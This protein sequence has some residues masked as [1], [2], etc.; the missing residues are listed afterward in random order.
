MKLMNKRYYSFGNP[1]KV[2]F[3]EHYCY[4]CGT[5]LFQTTHRK[6]VYPEAEEAKF[7]EFTDWDG[8]MFGPC[9]F[10]HKVFYCSECREEIEFITQ[11]NMEDIDCLL[12]KVE[13]MYNNIAQNTSSKRFSVNKY[14]ETEDGLIENKITKIENVRYLCISV[15]ENGKELKLQKFP[16]CRKKSWER[17]Y[18]FRVSKRDLIG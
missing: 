13:K 3:R 16:L 2:N 17:P 15:K 4:K 18:Y 8:R 10:I 14:F 7:Y 6:V 11:I 12:S 9:E 5:K 1:I